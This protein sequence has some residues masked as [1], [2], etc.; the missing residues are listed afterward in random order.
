MHETKNACVREIEE[1]KREAGTCLP[2]CPSLPPSSLPEGGRR[3][4]EGGGEAGSMQNGS[5]AAAVK[6]A[7][8]HTESMPGRER[9]IHY[10]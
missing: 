8:W 10:I 5:K 6:S 1:G 7:W 4:R 2:A 3:G 9:D